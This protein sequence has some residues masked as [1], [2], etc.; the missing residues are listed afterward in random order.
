MIVIGSL[1]LCCSL[2]LRED[3][4][5]ACGVYIVINTWFEEFGEA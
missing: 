1:L 4:N 5:I 3:S 2:S